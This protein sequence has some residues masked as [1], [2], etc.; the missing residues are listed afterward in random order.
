MNQKAVLKTLAR[1]KPM[2]QEKYDV[3]RLG[4]F[5]SV[6]RGEAKEDSD[7]DIVIQMTRP[8]LF[9]AANIKEELETALQ[10]PVDLVRLR[11]R[12]NQALKRRIEQEAIYV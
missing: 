4:V 8:N 12:M 5:G 10:C 2:L 3:T 9:V 1:C 6:A 7:V 11:K